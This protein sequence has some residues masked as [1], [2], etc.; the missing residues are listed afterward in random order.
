MEADGDKGDVRGRGVHEK[1]GEDGEICEADGTAV[2]EGERN[3]SYVR[4]LLICSTL[5]L[6][7]GRL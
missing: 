7:H 2:Q 4:S 5:P 1:T 3:T 6:I